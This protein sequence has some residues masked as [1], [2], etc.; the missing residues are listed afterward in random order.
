VVVVTSTVSAGTGNTSAA[1]EFGLLAAGGALCPSKAGAK[2]LGG[3]GD[4]AGDTKEG[5][6]FLR[7]V[8][9]PLG[10]MNLMVRG[11]GLLRISLTAKSQGL[12][13]PRRERSPI[14]SMK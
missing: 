13:S 7:G 6:E 10:L 11:R 9:D 3:D 2:D 12:S 8:D 4:S 14:D 1:T 5:K